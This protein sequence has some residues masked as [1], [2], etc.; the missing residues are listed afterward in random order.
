[1]TMVTVLDPTT[2]VDEIVDS[3]GPD[4]GPIKGRRVGLR[5]DIYW[6]SWTWVADE[7]AQLLRRDGAIVDRWRHSPPVGKQ[8]AQILAEFEA[9]LDSVEMVVIGMC[10]CGACTMWAVHDAMISLERNLPTVVASTEQFVQLAETL[11]ARSGRREIRI[12]ELPFPLEGLAED[13]VRA[14]ARDY[15]P[16]MLASLG[17]T[18]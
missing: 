10:N 4:G 16:A 14:I 7:W 9:F 18:A 2:K 3:R 13:D 12:V 1:M 8:A 15:Y 11:A 6:P 5:T 17:A